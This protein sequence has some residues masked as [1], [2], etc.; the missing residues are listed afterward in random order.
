[1][2]LPLLLPSQE[3]LPMAEVVVEGFSCKGIVGIVGICPSSIGRRSAGWLAIPSDRALPRV[4]TVVGA[5]FADGLE[6]SLGK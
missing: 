5:L 6:T 3:L 4:L 1:M 2:H